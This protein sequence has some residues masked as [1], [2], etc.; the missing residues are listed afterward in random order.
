MGTRQSWRQGMLFIFLIWSV[1]VTVP[2]IRMLTK[3]AIFYGE[4]G[5]RYSQVKRYRNTQPPTSSHLHLFHYHCRHPHSNLWSWCSGGSVCAFVAPRWLEVMQ[6][7][8]QA[9]PPVNA[10][11][12]TPQWPPGPP[13]GRMREPL[14]S[15][16]HGLHSAW[17][18]PSN[19]HRGRTPALRNNSHSLTVFPWTR[20]L[21][22]A[23]REKTLCTMGAIYPV[24]VIA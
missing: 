24:S 21:C 18:K 6:V 12:D 22:D 11:A 10:P 1:G 8:V 7:C 17:Q 16:P 19:R 2:L 4:T 23:D 9:G 20:L 14:R 13:Q 3:P 5:K 15:R